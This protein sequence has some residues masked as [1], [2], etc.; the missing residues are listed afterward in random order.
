MTKFFL[1]VLFFSFP[2]AKAVSQLRPEFTASVTSGCLPVPVAL[3][4]QSTGN[5]DAWK[6]DFGDGRTSTLQNPSLLY[7][8]AGSYTV[9]LT[10]Y[11]GA[12]DSA[13]IEK[14]AYINIYQEP[15]VNFS[16]TNTDGCIP[17]KVQFNDLSTPGSGTIASHNWDFGDGNS[18]TS[19]NPSHTYTVT[20][21]YNVNLTVRNS[22]GCVKTFSIPNLVR[23]RDS[24]RTDFAM[25]PQSSCGAPFIVDFKDRTVGNNIVSWRW[26]FGNGQTSTQ[27]NP[28]HSYST[29]GIYKVQLISTNGQGCSDTLS[30]DLNIVVGNFSASFTAP[31]KVCR[32]P[33]VKFENTSTPLASADSVRWNFGDGTFSTLVSPDKGFAT[34]GIYTVELSMYYGTCIITATRNIEV[35]AG[36]KTDFSAD[37]TEACQPPL[38]VRFTNLSTNGSV[39]RWNLGNGIRTGL[40]NPTTNYTD[41]GSYTVSLITVN[42]L[43]CYDTLTKPGLIKVQPPRIIGIPGLPFEGCF[44]WTQTFRPN[45]STLVPIAKFEWD[46]G[47][48][49]TSDLEQPTITYNVR[50]TY[51]VKLKVTTANGCMDSIEYTV[52]GGLKPRP[53]FTAQPLLVCPSD[54]VEFSGNIAGQYDSIRWE[55]GDGGQA[56]NNRFPVYNYRDT[57]WMTVTLFAYDNGCVDSLEVLNYLYVSPPFANFRVEAACSA[58][59][60]RRFIDSSFGASKWLWNFGNGDTSNERNPSYTYKLPGAY[61]VELEVSEGNCKHTKTM[62]VLVLDERPDFVFNEIKTCVDNQVTFTAQGP[63]LN[64]SNVR[65]FTWR[66]GDNINFVNAGSSITRKFT[67]NTS[68]SLRLQITDLNGCQRNINKN[69]NISIGGPKARILPNPILACLNSKVVFGDS[70]QRNQSSP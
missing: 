43:G 32:G 24:I 8:V 69:I 16:A 30:K 52:K 54:D 15:V 50:G 27:Q 4:D 41:N 18:S 14:T 58:P 13:T 6:W 47:N 39:H 48:G 35:L 23:V 21:R 60:D 36:P 37:V 17:L 7:L 38:T 70:S 66:F 65:S 53:T 61:R 49:Q 59:F 3:T 56:F 5:P 63:N 10:I 68:T 46:F 29:P 31:D 12:T 26:N 20:G 22:F 45:I 28:T 44:P 67:Q 19:A 62:E 2:A 9:K 57:G 25:V 1:W 55:F 33:R 34:P 64:L 11:K 51:K 42:A 40:P